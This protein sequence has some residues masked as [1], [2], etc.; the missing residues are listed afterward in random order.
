MICKYIR[1]PDERNMLL[2]H[3]F[4]HHLEITN[5]R[6]LGFG[7]RIQNSSEHHSIAGRQERTT[8]EINIAL[9]RAQVKEGHGGKAHYNSPDSR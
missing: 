2:L 9:I 6:P 8:V 7:Q 5:L 3:T 4:D 1:W